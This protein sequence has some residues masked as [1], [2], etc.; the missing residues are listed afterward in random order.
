MSAAEQSVLQVDRTVSVVADRAVGIIIDAQQLN[1]S[2]PGTTTG[3]ALG[4][5]FASAAYVDRA[6][7]GPTWNYS[8]TTHLSLQLL[9]T[10]LGSTLDKRA[11]PAYVTRY[12]VKLLDS[13][14]TTVDQTSPEPFRQSTGLCVYVPA[15]TPTIDQ[16]VCR[17]TPLTAPRVAVY[18]EHQVKNLPQDV[19]IK[20]S[21]ELVPCKL[22]IAAPV[23]LTAQQCNLAKGID[24]E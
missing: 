21:P 13:S 10:I 8:A 22:G 23:K 6:F 4:G 18:R 17:S 24:V 2:S 7:S 9:G 1:A 12:T 15:M 11:Q 19:A 14:I 20:D 5:S 3:A 16:E